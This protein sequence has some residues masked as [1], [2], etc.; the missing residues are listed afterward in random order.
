MKKA[1]SLLMILAVLLAATAASISISATASSADSPAGVTAAA[2]ASVQETLIAQDAAVTSAEDAAASSGNGVPS[3][4]EEAVYGILE[5][6]GSVR[7]LYV[8]NIFNGGAVTDYGSYSEVRNLTTSENLIHDG[9]RITIDTT[10]E[11]FYY[12]G[13]LQ[14]KELPWEIAIKYYL[15]DKQVSAGELAGKSGRLKIAVS[16]KRNDKANSRFFDNYALQIALTLNSRLCSDIA[17]D[18]AVIAEAGGKKQITWT[19]LPG[20]GADV[21]ATANVHDFE[22]DSVTINGIKLAFGIETDTDMFSGEIS[23]L[24]DA[25]KELD[26]GAGELLDGLIQLSDGMRKYTEGLKAFNDGI[27]QL[28]A[29]AGQLDAGASALRDGLQQLAGQNSLLMDG[30]YAMQLAT[31]DSVNAQLKAMDPRMPELTPENYNEVFSQ[32]SQ[33]PG[34][35]QMPGIPDMISDVKKQLDGVVQFTQGLKAYTDGV[36][37]L[38][39]GAGELARGAGE[40]SSSAVMIASS[41]NELYKAAVEL[42]SGMK[43][44]R[45]GLA[46]YKD[47]TKKLRDGTSGI[48]SEIEKKVDELLAGIMGTDEKP[49]SFVS[50]KNTNVAAVQFVLRTDPISTPKAEKAAVQEPAELTFWQKLLKLFG[51]YRG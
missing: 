32:I 50:D 42:D 25:I 23:Q 51:L 14:K 6:D 19:V 44:L 43:K 45:E 24:A 9:D 37:Q 4:K 15:D 30:A 48:D 3:P 31:F 49:A 35:S 17:A 1:I 12:Q 13:T 38:G 33:M 36:A 22:M 39:A 11:K 16:V 47:G 26:S 41:S 5:H 7:D 28:S 8:V 10:A 34:L 20:Q 40:F 27:G 21:S 29:G 46:A 2:A 18:D